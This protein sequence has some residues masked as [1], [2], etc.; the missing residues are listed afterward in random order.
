MK[1]ITFW[2]SGWLTFT[3]NT[4]VQSFENIHNFFYELLL[5]SHPFFVYC[6]WIFFRQHHYNNYKFRHCSLQ[7]WKMK[8]CRVCHSW[9]NSYLLNNQIRVFALHTISNSEN[10]SF[11]ITFQ[12]HL[13]SRC[14]FSKIRIT[15]RIQGHKQNKEVLAGRIYLWE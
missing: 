10:T 2:L 13:Y 6:K 14:T 11:H 5:Y 15:S 3:K 9:N 4:D 8:Q 12:Y 7:F 1:K